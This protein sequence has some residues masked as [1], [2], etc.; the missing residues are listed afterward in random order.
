MTTPPQKRKRTPDYSEDEIKVFVD[1]F[2]ANHSLL[3]SKH[4]TAI[5]SKAKADVYD[6]I[7]TAVNAV[8]VAPR[9]MDSIKD[10]WQTI[11]K[12]VKAKQAKY[13]A[14]ARREAAATGGGPQQEAR[15]LVDIT[16]CQA[17]R[18]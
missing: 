9:T 12:A 18:L 14:A 7:L 6:E 4:S 17:N 1:Q 3:S 16:G 5:T 13:L 10:K 15:I 2:V 11:K 8:G